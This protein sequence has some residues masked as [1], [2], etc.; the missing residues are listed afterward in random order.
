MSKAA[1]GYYAQKVKFA[2]STPLFYHGIRNLLRVN[3]S[4]HDTYSYPLTIE[5][6][7]DFKKKCHSIS[8]P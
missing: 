1:V 4:W 8:P 3:N 6:E 7:P 2:I 5:K